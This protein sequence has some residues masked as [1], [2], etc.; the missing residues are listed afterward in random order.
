MNK[1]SALLAISLMVFPLMAASHSNEYLDSHPSMS[2]HGGQT[3]M[4]G[5]YHIEIVTAEKDITVYMT[6]HAG[7][8][9]DVEIAH[10]SATIMN[11]DETRTV[12]KLTAAGENFLNGSGEFT[13]TET[14]GVWVSVKFP[15]EAAWRS[16]FTP[17]AKR[18]VAA[19]DPSVS[20]SPVEHD[21]S[22]HQH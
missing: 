17:L 21:H 11:A 13:I 4:A 12:I 6:D 15:D 9:I 16:K 1:I 10:G 2:L 8:P 7:N 5:P 3:H 19:D 18:P 20:K 22:A 14:T